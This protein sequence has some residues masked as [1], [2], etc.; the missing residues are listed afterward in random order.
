MAERWGVLVATKRAGRLLA[1]SWRESPERFADRLG[2]EGD[3]AVQLF[4]VAGLA[5]EYEADG[6]VL[7]GVV[8]EVGAV[9]DACGDDAVGHRAG[10]AG[11]D[12]ADRNL[13]SAL[14]ESFG[15]PGRVD[16]GR[17]GADEEQPD[18]VAGRLGAAQVVEFRLG[19]EN[20]FE[21][22]ALASY[23]CFFAEGVGEAGRL[24]NGLGRVPSTETFLREDVGVDVETVAKL[25]VP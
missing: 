3:G 5:A 16:G 11:D 7:R 4:D 2:P 13:V 23:E 14:H 19:R 15:D 6:T 9:R 12:L 18:K 21:G 20:G 25:L 24:Q 22:N 1:P 10:K 17:L 8:V